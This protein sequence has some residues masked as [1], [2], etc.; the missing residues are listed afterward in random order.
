MHME[1]PP[2]TKEL[3]DRH[4]VVGYGGSYKGAGVKLSWLRILLFVVLSD[5]HDALWQCRHHRPHRLSCKGT[6]R[7]V[8]TLSFARLPWLPCVPW[9]PNWFG[10][11]WYDGGSLSS[12]GIGIIDSGSFAH[13]WVVGSYDRGEPAVSYKR[14]GWV[15]EMTGGSSRLQE[16]YGS[17]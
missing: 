6:N 17:F 8:C 13:V 3:F 2:R 4:S 15:W 12:I 14:T 5:S 9:G 11:Q 16:N 1:Q 7:K 10:K